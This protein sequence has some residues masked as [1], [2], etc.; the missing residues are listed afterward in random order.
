VPEARFPRILYTGSPVSEKNSSSQLVISGFIV[1][2][3]AE[4]N[5]Q[6]YNLSTD[7]QEGDEESQETGSSNG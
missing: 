7:D 2:F 4:A 6:I 5:E 3:G 1:L